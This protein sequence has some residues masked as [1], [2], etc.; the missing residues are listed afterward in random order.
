ML[1]ARGC[2]LGQAYPIADAVRDHFVVEVI[3]RVVKVG[4]IAVADEDERARTGLQHEREI[5][6]AHGRCYVSI[7]VVGAGNF[8][9]DRRREVC[10]VRVVE[11]DR[12]AL[13]V[14][15]GCLGI[16]GIGDVADDLPNA[17]LGQFPHFRRQRSHGAAE[18]GF[19]GND[20]EGCPGVE[21]GD[22]NNDRIQWI[23]VARRNQ[24]H[25]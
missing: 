3:S 22:R 5:L 20:I 11:C 18:I 23:G 10:L 25:A 19:L 2:G 12:I 8:T 1:L 9:G 14:M 16:V 4:G 17:L 6:T 7:H 15:D 21:L 13:A 24:L